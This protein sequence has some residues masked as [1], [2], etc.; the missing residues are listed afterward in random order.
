MLGSTPMGGLGL[1]WLVRE[2]HTV[3]PKALEMGPS[4]YRRAS[5]FDQSLSRAVSCCPASSLTV[6]IACSWDVEAWNGSLLWGDR[7][8]LLSAPFLGSLG[9]SP[10]QGGA[11][12]GRRGRLPGGLAPGLGCSPSPRKVRGQ[13][14]HCF[15]FRRKRPRC[16][17]ACLI[18][19]AAALL[20]GWAPECQLG[21]PCL[22]VTVTKQAQGAGS[23][24]WMVPRSVIVERRR[25][26]KQSHFQCLGASC[27][28]P[29]GTNACK[30]A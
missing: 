19:W 29:A 25:S 3:V 26:Y 23:P 18:S 4:P 6:S 16:Q 14:P 15:C 22:L 20:Q 1:S 10:V 21:L 8:P 17:C 11:G 7:G 24:G 2:S 9:P 13:Q 27:K 5:H 28:P 30:G 12:R